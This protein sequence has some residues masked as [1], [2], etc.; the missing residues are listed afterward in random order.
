MDLLDQGSMNIVEAVKPSIL[1]E[2]D[3]KSIGGSWQMCITHVTPQLKDQIVSIVIKEFAG[4]DHLPT[5]FTDF[6][7]WQ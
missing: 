4:I 7:S 5:Q 3:C 1:I 2:D 6:M